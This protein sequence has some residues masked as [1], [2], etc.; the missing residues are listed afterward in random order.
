MVA[1]A[2]EYAAAGSYEEAV[3]LLEDGHEAKVLAGGQSLMPMLNLRFARPE[4]LIDINAA[5]DREPSVAGGVLR[6]PALT[7]HRV[8]PVPLLLRRPFPRP[9]AAGPGGGRLAGRAPAPRSRRLARA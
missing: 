5:D 8:L 1:P 4:L 9:A 7:P 2:L 6:L 3:R